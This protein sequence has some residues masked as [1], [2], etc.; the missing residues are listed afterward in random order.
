MGS[1]DFQSKT[2]HPILSATRFFLILKA[3][4]PSTSSSMFF[5]LFLGT[6][7]MLASGYAGEAHFMPAQTGFVS[8][9][10]GWG[11][12]LYEIF[13]GEASKAAGQTANEYMAYSFST[14][15]F[16][17]T[18]GWAIYPAGYVLVI[19]WRP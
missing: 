12:I 13:S 5:R 15:R 9:M 11:F 8:G 7:W 18:A 14:M 6:V 10:A 2:K 3:V 1:A 16:I 17:V 4:T 19:C